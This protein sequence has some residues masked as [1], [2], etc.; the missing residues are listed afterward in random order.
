MVDPQAR[1]DAAEPSH[2]GPIRIAFR[3][4]PARPNVP[5]HE[6]IAEELEDE[7]SLSIGKGLA[8]IERDEAEPPQQ[9]VQ[10]IASYIDEV[11][12]GR[13]RLPREADVAALA[14]ACL[15]GQAVCRGLGWGWGHVRRTRSPGIVVIS[16]DLRYAIGPRAVVDAA[17]ASDGG[18]AVLSLWKRLSAPERLPPSEPGRY[19]RI[20]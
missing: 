10:A 6:Q 17:Q 4:R 16:R 18:S 9:I 11:R 7:L 8:L 5:Y 20:E 19:R 2:E 14:L 1:M 13:A 12:A 15:L 3:A